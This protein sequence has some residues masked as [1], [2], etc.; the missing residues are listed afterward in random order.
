MIYDL[1]YKERNKPKNNG[2]VLRNTLSKMKK[3]GLL[4]NEKGVWKITP[5]GKIFLKNENVS[6]IK[7]SDSKNKNNKL[8]KT[9]MVVFD[10]PE[11]KRLYRNWLRNELVG[12][13]FTLIQKSVW[14]GPALPKEFISYLSDRKILEYV[15]FFKV[16]END[17]I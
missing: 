7:F 3:R 14:F 10:I 16:T 12:F 2:Q 5:E 1:I 4:S 15:R 8:P 17:L 6:L 9:T 13:G 11:K